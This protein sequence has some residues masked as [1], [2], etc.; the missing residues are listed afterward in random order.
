[1]I[2]N[3]ILNQ[4]SLNSISPLTMILTKFVGLIIR[5]RGNVIYVFVL[6]FSDSFNTALSKQEH[7]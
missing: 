2:Q 6:D 3:V 1:M 4:E 5:T 7:V